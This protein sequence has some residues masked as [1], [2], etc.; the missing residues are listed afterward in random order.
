LKW[1]E[2][3]KPRL[4]IKILEILATGKQLTVSMAEDILKE[5]HHPEIWNGFNNLQHKGLIEESKPTGSKALQTK[6]QGKPKYYQIAEKGLYVLIPEAETA[7][8]FWR[9]MIIYFHRR[10][11]IVDI[12]EFKDLYEEFVNK[13]LKYLS[14]SRSPMQLDEFYELTEAWFKHIVNIS[15]RITPDQKFLEVLALNPAITFEQI[16]RYTGKP[17]RE[18][19]IKAIM[20]RYTKIYPKIIHDDNSE[21]SYNDKYDVDHEFDRFVITRHNNKTGSTTYELSLFGVMLVLSLIIYNH[22]GTLKNGLY[23]NDLSPDIIVSNYSDKLPLVFGQSQWNLLKTKLKQLA[24]YNFA[25]IFDKNVLSESFYEP[26]LISGKQE[27]YDIATRISEY[28]KKQIDEFR[29]EFYTQYSKYSKEIT[30]KNANETVDKL[31]AIFYLGKRTLSSLPYGPSTEI[32]VLDK[33]FAEEIAFLYYLSLYDNKYFPGE[34]YY[35]TAMSKSSNTYDMP[36]VSPINILSTVIKKDKQIRMLFSSWIQD[37]IDY[38]RET[39]KTIEGFYN[40]ID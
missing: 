13:H 10:A 18:D 39:L 20:P 4:Q 5:H 9:A 16:A 14:R 3:R 31:D 25:I 7:G 24:F 32:D 40:Q 28:R 34:L 37:I 27:L 35:S 29:N 22:M 1:Y 30:E 15:K 23:R 33:A 12:D 2:G 6:G 26:Y 17:V 21:A 8:K 36:S 38:Q 11:K 19:Q